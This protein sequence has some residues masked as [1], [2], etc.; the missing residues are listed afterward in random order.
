M[1][2]PGDGRQTQ[3]F[4]WNNQPGSDSR[5]RLAPS[6]SFKRFYDKVGIKGVS[7]SGSS[8]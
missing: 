6:H 4:S 8:D 1:V 3:L 2:W 7:E 5:D